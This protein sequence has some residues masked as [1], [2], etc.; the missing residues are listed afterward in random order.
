MTSL[1]QKLV[2]INRTSYTNATLKQ[3][4]LIMERYF[5]MT[6]IASAML[7]GC[8]STSNTSNDVANAYQSINSQ[9]LAEHIKVLASDEFG[10]RAPSSKGEELTLAYLTDQ[11]KA[12]GFQPG[13]GDSPA[14][15]AARQR[16]VD[17]RRRCHRRQTRAQS[18]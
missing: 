1:P 10:G 6:V 5:S 16:T 17:P 15:A 8:A 9:Q 2:L 12:L 3:K 7:V 11:F 14:P 18:G 4:R 13:N